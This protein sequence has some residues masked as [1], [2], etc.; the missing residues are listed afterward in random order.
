MEWEELLMENGD[1][2]NT[3]WNVFH[4]KRQELEA[5]FVPKIKIKNNKKTL[6]IPTRW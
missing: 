4:S 1:D 6:R 5:K 2:I 3:I